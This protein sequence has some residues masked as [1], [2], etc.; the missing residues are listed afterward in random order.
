MALHVAE[1]SSG[2]TADSESAYGQE[3]IDHVYYYDNEDGPISESDKMDEELEDIE[4][5]T[6]FDRR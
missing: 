1:S 4:Y 5:R 6:K 3:E 2:R